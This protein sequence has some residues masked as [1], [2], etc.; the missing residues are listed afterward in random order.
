MQKKS[1]KRLKHHIEKFLNDSDHNNI[2]IP[3]S[4]MMLDDN[5]FGLKPVEVIEMTNEYAS[6]Q[7]RLFLTQREIIEKQNEESCHLNKEN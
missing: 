3:N 7:D 4:H 5:Y 2:N 6:S 1:N